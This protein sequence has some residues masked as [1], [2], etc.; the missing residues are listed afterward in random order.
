MKPCDLNIKQTLEITEKMIK[1]AEQGD[2]FIDENEYGIR[3]GILLDS[4]YKIRKIAEQEKSAH[5]EKEFWIKKQ[6]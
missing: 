3:Y 1:L 6:Q 5:I 4:A 2:L